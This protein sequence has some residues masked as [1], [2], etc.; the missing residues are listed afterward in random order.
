MKHLVDFENQQKSMSVWCE[1]SSAGCH[2][3]SSSL[4]LEDV[5]AVRGET[6]ETWARAKVTKI[7]SNRLGSQRSFGRRIS[8]VVFFCCCCSLVELFFVDSGA[9]D[10]ADVRS[11][12]KQSPPMLCE[13]PQQALQCLLSGVTLVSSQWDIL[14]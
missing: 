14:L 5:V 10:Y 1:G 8:G 7:I 4:K 13:A 6:G 3:T 2:Q 9:N 12:C 11:I